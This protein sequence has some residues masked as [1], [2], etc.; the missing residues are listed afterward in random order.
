MLVMSILIVGAGANGGYLG[1]QLVDAGRVVTVLVHPGA[2]AVLASGLRIRRGADIVTIP[3]NAVTAADVD[4]AYDVVVVAVRTDAV[5]SA[6]PS[7]R[8]AV[9]AATRI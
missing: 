2:T 6:T 1:G 5:Q 7:R 4:T 3:V 8:T 9:G